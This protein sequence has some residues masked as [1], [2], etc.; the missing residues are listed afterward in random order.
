MTRAV[1]NKYFGISVI[2]VLYVLN[3]F[4]TELQCNLAMR[5]HLFWLISH[6]F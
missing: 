2:N 1:K 4:K 3:N 5:K 6:I